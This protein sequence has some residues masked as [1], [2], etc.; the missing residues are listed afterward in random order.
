MNEEI[1]K[2]VD[3]VKEAWGDLISAYRQLGEKSGF[4]HMRREEDLRCFFYCKIM[5]VLQAHDEFLHHL[6][7]EVSISSKWIDIALGTVVDDED[8]WELGIE[9][10]NSDDTME[11]KK[12]LEKLRELI[13]NKNIAAG[14]FV[15]MTQHSANLKDK[16][17]P[18]NLEYKIEE[19]EKGDNNFSKW[20]RIKVDKY[21][22]DWDAL[23]IVV[24]KV[25]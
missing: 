15:T 3:T 4:V 11:I 17:H 13:K 8:K 2:R 19:K 20:E 14:L 24:R 5:E 6:H 9:I 1:Q 25:D 23:L 16:L 10:K 22:V 18:I 7:A 21:D 12:D